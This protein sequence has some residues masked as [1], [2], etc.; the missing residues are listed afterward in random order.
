LDAAEAVDPSEGYDGEATEECVHPLV[1]YS[2]KDSDVYMEI[3][4]REGYVIDDAVLIERDS[5][6]F[7]YVAFHDFGHLLDRWPT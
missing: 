4:G 3:F 2:S 5:I 7:F 6:V 1:I